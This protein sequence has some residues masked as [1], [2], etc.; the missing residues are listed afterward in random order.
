MATM[1]LSHDKSRLTPALF[2]VIV[3]L[4][5]TGP[6]ATDMYLPSFPVMQ[7]EFA[8]TAS[9]VQLTLT[10]FFVGMALGQLAWGA[11]SDRW[12]RT[13]PL[14]YG[15][16]IFVLGSIAAA[17]APT[18]E[19]LVAARALQGLG[20]AAGLVISKAIVADVT[21]G[22]RTARIFSILM[23]IGGVAPALAPI[24]GAAVAGAGGWRAVLWVLAGVALLMALGSVFI[25]CET[26]PRPL[27]STGR[28]FAP[29][30]QALRQPRFVGY[31]LQFGFAFGAMMSYISA[32]PF[33]YQNVMG[34]SSTGYALG[35]G[36][37]AVGLI[38]AGL[39]SARLALRV[40]LRRTVGVG[41]LLLA[42]FSTLMLALALSGV[43]SLL[44]AVVLFFMVSSVG[45]IMGNTTGLALEE[46]RRISGSGSAAL[47][48]MQFLVGALISPLVGLSGED[49]PVAFAATA[50]TCML[51]TLAALIYTADRFHP[52]AA[53]PQ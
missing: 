3:L 53:D 2:A 19:T 32:S 36:V 39:L 48:C 49:S 15:T 9:A 41:V 50:F 8:T 45:M 33:L 27:R 52:R 37:N 20:A 34:L 28:I 5:T 10:A 46:V 44:L 38:I 30:G 22:P 47:G 40:P 17:L 11:F 23:T 1:P 6:L 24:L 16:G 18:L 7:R 13:A 43:R 25:V 35:F 14:R 21:S 29:L 26:H 51:I 4:G 42:A 31:M 12:G